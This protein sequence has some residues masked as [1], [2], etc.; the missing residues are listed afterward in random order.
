M[1]TLTPAV[2]LDRD[3][4]LIEDVPYGTDPAKVRLFPGVREA[5]ARLKTAGFRNVIVTNQSGVGRG[6]ISPTQ[7]EAIH[8]RLLELLGPDLIDATYFCP[9]APGVPSD[10]RKPAPGMLLRAAKDLRLDLTQSW[11]IGDKTSDLECGRNAGVRSI[12]VLT[13]EGSVADP[14]AAEFVAEDIG[15]AVEFILR[16][17]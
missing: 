11:L 13:G 1:S 12:L 9:D 6:W 15:A 5:L 10:E 3:G 16:S 4:T 8:A 7:Y 2:F 14:S 17:Q